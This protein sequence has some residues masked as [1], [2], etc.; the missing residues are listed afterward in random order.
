VVDKNGLNNMTW[1]K[2]SAGSFYVVVVLITIGFLTLYEYLESN[3]DTLLQGEEKHRVINYITSQ[4]NTSM[5]ELIGSG[6]PWVSN[7]TNTGVVSPS[8]VTL[9]ED[10]NSLFFRADMRPI[11]K[12]AIRGVGICYV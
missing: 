1:H 2:L 6:M 8:Q 3:I 9:P 11:I 4:S 10:Y 5:N 12:D 7:E